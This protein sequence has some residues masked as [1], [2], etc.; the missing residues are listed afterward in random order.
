L[1]ALRLNAERQ[2]SLDDVPAPGGPGPGELQVAIRAVALNHIDVWGW[3]GMAFAR[4]ELPIIAGAEA[5]GEVVA[6][7]EGASPHRVG[8]T[9]A[10]YGAATC[11][12]CP[13][14]RA[15]SDNLCES[16]AGVFGFHLDGFCCD[17]RN[18]DAR[19]AVRA[20]DGVDFVAAALTPIT[21]GTAEH[22]LF[23][24]A[25]LSAGQWVLVQA[26]GSGVGS[27]AIQLAK[28]AGATVITTVGSADKAE[29]AARLGADHVINYR[30][31]RFETVVRRITGRRG[32]DVVFEHVGAETFAGSILSLRRGGH[33]VTCGA[34]SG[35]KGELNLFQLFQQQ[36]RLIG[37][38]GC[39]IANMR[40]C[41]DKLAR[42]AV[43]PVIDTELA[44]ADFARGVARLEAR[45]VFGKI[46]VRM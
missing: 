2:L 45:D 32:V 23:D 1:R 31:E 24:N 40:S 33:L 25:R 3:R 36:L 46:V 13:A 14:C 7:G 16:V 28:D 38:F 21:F 30:E 6:V 37:S 10:L 26:G 42:G 17:L 35:M 44:L 19:L 41:L 29:K 11:G 5:S 43:R 8:D 20:P 9:V 39:R 4:R 12:T 22:M 34:T 27:A 18:I 15:G